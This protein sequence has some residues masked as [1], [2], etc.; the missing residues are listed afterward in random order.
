MNCNEEFII[1]TIGKLSLEFN[2]DW[3]QQRKVRECLDYSLY[4]YEVQTLEKS[5]I[6]GDIPEKVFLY[7][8]VKQLAGYSKLT[9]KNYSYT[10]VR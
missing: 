10:L 2:L 1:K 4:N 6:K 7:L 9:L 8:K 3:E 5:L